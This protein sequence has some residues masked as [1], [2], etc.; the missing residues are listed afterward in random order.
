MCVGADRR[1]G[2]KVRVKDLSERKQRLI[3]KVTPTKAHLLKWRNYSSALMYT[4][5][6]PSA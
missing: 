6:Y 4:S 3:K 2:T 5:A 1:I